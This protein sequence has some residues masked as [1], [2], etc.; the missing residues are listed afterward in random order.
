[1]RNAFGIFMFVFGASLMVAGCR[2][3]ES[4]N[5]RP[6]E[7]RSNNQ[8]GNAPAYEQNYDQGG[9][10]GSGSRRSPILQGSGSR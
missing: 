3:S 6:Y 8:S 7:S 1:M 9:N 10:T 4:C 5:A 2:S